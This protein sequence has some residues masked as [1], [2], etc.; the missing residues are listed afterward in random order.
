[1]NNT[2]LLHTAIEL[3][4]VLNKSADKMLPKEI[5]D[6]V[7]LHSGIAVGSAWIPIPGVDMAAG[8]GN[9]WTMYVRI[10]NK[11]GLSV[12]DNILKT[13]A[14][15]VLTNLA[16]YLAVS[17]VASALKQKSPEDEKISFMLLGK[18]NK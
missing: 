9:I 7:K 17:G 2:H 15:G 13:I 6:V 18:R 8:A 16:G 4:E 14:S 10:N 5:S 3:V 12:K 1:M 11:I